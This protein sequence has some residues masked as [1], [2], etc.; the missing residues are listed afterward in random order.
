MSFLENNFPRHS[1]AALAVTEVEAKYFLH[2]ATMTSMMLA[3]FEIDSCSEKAPANFESKMC[4]SNGI[5]RMRLSQFNN[6]KVA[7]QG[8]SLLPSW[9]RS[10]QVYLRA[11]RSAARSLGLRV[12]SGASLCLLLLYQSIAC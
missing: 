12:G 11:R 9:P 5:S 1:D 3:S 8:N 10:C 2:K 7:S 4:K 6:T